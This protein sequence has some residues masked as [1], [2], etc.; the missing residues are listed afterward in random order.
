MPNSHSSLTSLFSDIAD[1]IR[2][3]T[4]YTDL[5]KAD[6]FPSKIREI[7]TLG[8]PIF[9]K[10]GTL[11]PLIKAYP[12]TEVGP[13]TSYEDEYVVPYID[14]ST[15][16]VLNLSRP[17]EICTKFK[18]DS[19]LTTQYPGRNI[20][21]SIESYY[22]C[23]TI[24]VHP[25]RIVYYVTETPNRWDYTKNIAPDNWA[26]PYGTWVV[27]KLSFDGANVHFYFHDG[28]NEYTDILQNVLP[29][30]N[31]SYSFSF[32]GQRAS[33]YSIAACGATIDFNN[34]Y[35]KQGNDIIWG[36]KES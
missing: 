25:T 7:Q 6:D 21:G 16:A 23:P 30:Y 14:G 13:S 12:E 36:H 26:F 17:F 19:D 32:L 3:K 34:T 11:N 35:L 29:Y 24:A 22:D 27:A 31:S 5:I 4:D 10:M 28:T 20:W 33:V 1:A 18:V 2:E 9:F 8:T 15:K